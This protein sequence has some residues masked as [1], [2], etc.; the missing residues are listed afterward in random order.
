MRFR[1]I[2]DR[3]TDYPVRILCRALEVSPAG[4]YAWRSRPESPR[5][6]ANRDLAESIRQAHRDSHGRYGSPR[7]H[8][9]LK[10][11][12]HSAS[13][14]RIE[15]QMRRH[16][17]RAIMTKPRRCRTTDSG[18]GFPIAPNL[19]GRNFQA[20]ARNQIWLNLRARFS[21]R[22][23][24]YGGQSRFARLTL[25]YSSIGPA[26]VRRRRCASRHVLPT[27]LPKR[28]SLVASCMMMS[29]TMAIGPA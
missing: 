27:S 23:L 25:C 16:G 7:I 4:Y 29:V 18:H 24:S 10:A 28:A 17:I 15:R 1:F 6:V 12:G 8:A 2:E 21:L 3:R 20:A 5:C 19:L 13:R 22:S 11:Q 14:G 26:R 9:E